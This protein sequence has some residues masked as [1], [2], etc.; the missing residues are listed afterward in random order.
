MPFIAILLDLLAFGVYYFQNGHDFSGM[1]WLGTIVQAIIFLILL[2]SCFTYNGRK[3]SKFA[4]Y[5]RVTSGYRHFS[6]GYAIIIFSTIVN[7]MVLFLYVLNV[8][9]INT[10]VFPR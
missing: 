5:D 10:L 3:L 4:T 1:F 7:A 8:L 9:D 2:V 6:F